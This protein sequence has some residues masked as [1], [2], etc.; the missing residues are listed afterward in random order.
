V[1]KRLVVVALTISMVSAPALAINSRDL[2]DFSKE[3]Q[4]RTNANFSSGY[5]LGYV[6]AVTDAM[7]TSLC[8]PD[9]ANYGNTAQKVKEYLIE[10]PEISNQ[11][12]F[13]PV[14]NV[15]QEL[16]ACPIKK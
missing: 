13:V 2:Y 12:A 4:G 10:H 1:I 3:Y 8:V 11:D 6:A 15:L 16:Y 7:R 5:F 14:Y 9:S